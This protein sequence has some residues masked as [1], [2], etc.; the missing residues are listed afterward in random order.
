MDDTFNV[1]FEG[2]LDSVEKQGADLTHRVQNVEATL[3][4]H[5]AKMDTMGV[6]LDQIVT[7]VTRSE[8]LP[9]VNLKEV[10]NVTKD[11]AILSGLVA[12]LLAFIIN[13]YGAA[14]RAVTSHR[15]G[16]LE[17]LAERVTVIPKGSNQ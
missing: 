4:H 1:R 7:A 11:L 9:K 10:L 6:K 17:R 13:S 12:G 3:R 8:A 5:G 2:R 15:L 16:Q 14:D